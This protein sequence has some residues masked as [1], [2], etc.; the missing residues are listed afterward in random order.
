[1]NT[2]AK[3][4]GNRMQRLRKQADLTQ[5]EL[6]RLVGVSRTM[7]TNLES[8]TTDPSISVL[9]A[10]AQTLECST[11]FLLGLAEEP[12]ISTDNAHL[13]ERIRAMYKALTEIE[14]LANRAS[15]PY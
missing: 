14:T 9:I 11:D 6:G 5:D 15:I 8:C 1:M 2:E 3:F 4:H 10:I 13:Y 12:T 7:I